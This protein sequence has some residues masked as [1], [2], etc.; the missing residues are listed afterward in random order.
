MVKTIF[1]ESYAKQLRQKPL[2]DNTVGRGIDI[3]LISMMRPSKFVLQVDE[4]TGVTRDAHFT[5]IRYE[6]MKI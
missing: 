1:G 3:I 5:Y 4:E 6:K 2:A